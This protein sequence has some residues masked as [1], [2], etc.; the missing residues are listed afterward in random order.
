MTTQYVTQRTKAE[1]VFPKLMTDVDANILDMR[2]IQEMDSVDEVEHMMDEYLK[3][4]AWMRER[5]DEL[6]RQGG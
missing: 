2:D 4:I 3:R 5:K 6:V 1:S